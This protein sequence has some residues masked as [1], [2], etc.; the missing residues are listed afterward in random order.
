MDLRDHLKA[1]DPRAE[2]ELDPAIAARAT[3]PGPL[4]DALTEGLAEIRL[5]WSRARAVHGRFLRRA[6][7]L[8]SRE[9]RFAGDLLAFAVRRDRTLGVLCERAGLSPSIRRERAA[10]ARI[11]AA[12]VLAAG[13]DHRQVSEPE[14]DWEAVADA[15]HTLTG[16]GMLE[17]P[18]PVEAFG[19]LASLPDHFAARMLD[20]P[21]PAGL[22]AALNRRASLQLRVNRNRTSRDAAVAA[23][24]E[25]GIDARPCALSADGIELPGHAD[26][27]GLAGVRDGALEVQDEGSQLIA[28]LCGVAPGARVVDA[29]AGALGKSLALASHME[30]RGSILATDPRADALARGAKRARRCGFTC[31]RTVPGDRLGRPDG[32][33]DAVLVDAPCSGSGALR[34][35]PWSRWSVPPHELAALPRLQASIL[36]E[37]SGWLRPG[38]RLVYATCSLF[39]DENEAVVQAFVEGHPGWSVQPLSTLLGPERAERIGD[40]RVL[41]LYPHRHGTDGFFAAVLARS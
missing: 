22:A 16:W 17:D 14:L 23:L 2:A 13:L 24:Q 26:V 32:K 27:H 33:A 6:R 35:R 15:A 39:A 40:G 18:G 1:L 28:E 12:L 34:R 37:A 20:L 19:V 29:C 21:D 38:G 30:G 3:R 9:R 7:T 25:Q 8:Q 4:R 5:D 10:L 31:I 11:Q 36:D 41:K